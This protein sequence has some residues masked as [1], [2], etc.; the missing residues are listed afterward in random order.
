[1]TVL[2][3]TVWVL[4]VA[5]ATRLITRD[6]ITEP[7]RNQIVTRYGVES[8]IT[9]LVHCTWCSGLWVSIAT[10]PAAIALTGLSWWLTPLLAG[11][12]SHLV[13]LLTYLED[14]A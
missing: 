7:L 14:E 6:K 8:Q 10:A 9:Y 1:M 5:R 11:A 13:G 12:A 2:I 4:A 3:L